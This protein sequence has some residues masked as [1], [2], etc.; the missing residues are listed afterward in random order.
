MAQLKK[1]CI[2][3]HSCRGD[4]A[5]CA[6]CGSPATAVV[7]CDCGFENSTE[8]AFCGDC[9]S[10]LSLSAADGNR[11]ATAKTTWAG[12]K[13]VLVIAAGIVVAIL[14]IVGGVI[15]T[16]HGQSDSRDASS[17]T[18]DEITESMVR[19]GFCNE[20]PTGGS[21]TLGATAFRYS[22][23]FGPDN[24]M[25]QLTV[26]AVRGDGRVDPTELNRLQC[27]VVDER[28]NALVLNRT[29]ITTRDN[30]VNSLL[31]GIPNPSA[32]ILPPELAN[33][34]DDIGFLWC[35]AFVVSLR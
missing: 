27:R 25:L 18:I 5:F 11:K 31:T 8:S 10:S 16:G 7:V 26:L 22:C 33:H 28:P 2:N 21:P 35:E 4:A 13:K 12:K 29:I 23:N 34:F 9:G 20:T 14:G 17:L 6:E 24:L 1:T 32:T 30:F 19:L 15:G 3:D